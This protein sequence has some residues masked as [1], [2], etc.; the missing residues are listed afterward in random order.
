MRILLIQN[1]AKLV[2]AR[3]GCPI[4]LLPPLVLGVEQ[5]LANAH[6]L[7]ASLGALHTQ[8]HRQQQHQAGRH[9]LIHERVANV[10]GRH[11]GRH[12]N[13]QGQQQV[14]DDALA[15][16]GRRHA[17]QQIPVAVVLQHAAARDGAAV[18]GFR[19]RRT[20]EV[21]NRSGKAAKGILGACDGIGVATFVSGFGGSREWIL[22]CSTTGCGGLGK[23]VVVGVLL[24]LG[25]RLDI[26]LCW[27]VPTNIIRS[28]RRRNTQIWSFCR[29]DE[30]PT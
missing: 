15:R 12:K 4:E 10:Q 16:R 23:A 7:G 17:R 29:A 21:G 1:R 6:A 24:L 25:R 28:S 30:T 5:I 22:R 18:D 14:H 3:G 19:V 20:K 2:V 13:R 8:V 27:L 9:H 11:A 26:L